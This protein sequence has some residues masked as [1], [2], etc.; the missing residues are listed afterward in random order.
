MRKN[1]VLQILSDSN[2]DFVKV[3]EAF[4]LKSFSTDKPEDVDAILG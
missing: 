4:G 3:G 2:P 1:T